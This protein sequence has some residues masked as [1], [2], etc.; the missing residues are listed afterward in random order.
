MEIE[1]SLQ[2]IKTKSQKNKPTKSSEQR[3]TNEQQ[4]HSVELPWSNTK[5]MTKT[6]IQWNCRGIKANHEELLLLLKKYNPK[7]VCLQE[8]FL[9]D[10]NY[11]K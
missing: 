10:I 9:K 7:I 2:E 6:I 5:K 1:N 11:Y 4:N 3:I 8:T